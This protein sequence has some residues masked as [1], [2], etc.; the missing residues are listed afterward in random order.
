MNAVV[1]VAGTGTRLRPL[2]LERPK[3][4]IELGGRSLLERL[5]DALVRV[6][7]REATLVVGYRAEAIRA[8]VGERFRGM[9]IRY[10]VNPDYERGPL[11]SLWTGR[12]RLIGD[13][14]LMDGDVLFAPELLKRLVRAETPSALVMD[15][16]FTDTGEEIKVY[17]EGPRVRA[18]RRSRQVPPPVPFD[19][20]GE[21]IGFFRVGTAEAPLLR[22]IVEERVASG[23][24]EGDYEET[25]DRLAR[26]AEVGWVSAAGLPWI[27]IDFPEDLRRAERE[28]LP[29]LADP[30]P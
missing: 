6:G 20:V 13:T 29:R 21:W 19:A 5:L 3:C 23:A 15:P 25:L 16:A 30:T 26:E 18:I 22:A 27:E 9:P 28:V 12:E 7:A 1:L 2:T 4:L 8:R 14:L 17:L 10:L 24:V 11:L